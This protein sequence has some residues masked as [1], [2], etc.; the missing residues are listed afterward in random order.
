MCDPLPKW[1]APAK[2]AAS[3]AELSLWHALEEVEDPEYPVSVVDM[4][5]IYGVMIDQRVAHIDLTFTS[6][7]LSVY[8]IHH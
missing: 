7:G 3:A 5:L 1:V 8:G 2:E 4:G 6:M